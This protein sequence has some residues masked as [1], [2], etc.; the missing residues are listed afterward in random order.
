MGPAHFTEG[1]RGK[2]FG[3][4][5][6]LGLQRAS[7]RDHLLAGELALAEAGYE[8]WLEAVAQT[9]EADVDLLLIAMER[10]IGTWARSVVQPEEAPPAVSGDDTP[11]VLATASLEGLATGAHPSN[12][13]RARQDLI[14]QLVAMDLGPWAVDAFGSVWP[15]R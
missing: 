5:S 4:A 14:D 7:V 8:R 11:V 3:H 15:I 10:D 9:G 1:G 12:S 6:A 13:D 2:V